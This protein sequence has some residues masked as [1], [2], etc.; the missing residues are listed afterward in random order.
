MIRALGLIRLLCL[1]FG[2]RGLAAVSG[3]KFKKD[4]DGGSACMW[5]SQMTSEL[6]KSRSGAGNAVEIKPRYS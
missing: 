6:G 3:L 5:L 2:V 1:V 4:A